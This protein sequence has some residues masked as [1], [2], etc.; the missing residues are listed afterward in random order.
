MR[1]LTNQHLI[2]SPKIKE[3]QLSQKNEEKRKK[4]Q[5][6]EGSIILRPS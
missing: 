1:K 5:D 4:H 2:D 6:L 3:R